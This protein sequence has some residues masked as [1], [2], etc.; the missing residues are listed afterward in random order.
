[1]NLLR[2]HVSAHPLIRLSTPRTSPPPLHPC[3]QDGSLDLD[4]LK[5]ALD[6]LRQASADADAEIVRLKK[7]RV[8]VWKQV[9][10]AQHELSCVRK[11]DEAEA[12]AKE[13]V[14]AREAAAAKED[15][16][17]RKAEK[18]AA[19]TE[20]R[21][22]AEEDKAAFAAK[23]KQRRNSLTSAMPSMNMVAVAPHTAP[24]TT[25]TPIRPQ[26]S[27]DSRVSGEG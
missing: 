19:A 1:M 23:V 22:K 2:T 18:L 26:G 17:A 15:E 6:R 20:A 10:V 7:T 25:S 11:T 4:E 12:S 3:A 13:E 16:E 14:K 9:K 5:L 24:P 21:R 8:E 27:R